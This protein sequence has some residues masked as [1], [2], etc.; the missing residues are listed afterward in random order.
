MVCDEKIG[1]IRRKEGVGNG[2]IR[3]EEELRE[4]GC[5]E[6]QSEG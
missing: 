1:I 5:I 4:E 2:S 3:E 6:R